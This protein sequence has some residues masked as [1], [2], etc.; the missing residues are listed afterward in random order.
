M[1]ELA[2]RD[3]VVKRGWAAPGGIH[4]FLIKAMKVLLPAGVGIML[5]YLLLSPL[6]RKA[7]ISFRLD[8][9]EV[10]VARERLKI[11][12]AQYRGTDNKGRPFVVDADSA[13][14]ATSKEPVVEIGGMAARIMLAEGLATLRARRG[15][16]DMEAQRVDVVGPILLTTADGYRLE[17]RDVAVDLNAQTLTGDK[18][19]EGTMPLGRFTAQRMKVDMRDR[20]VTLQGRARL[21]IEQ[22]GLR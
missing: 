7:E 11:Q 10:E 19:V 4:D 9:K 1:S 3:R 20:R 13:V 22:G 12:S 14:Q 2:E 21:H 15:R 8:K 6:S 16:Y 5:A 18:G 17:T